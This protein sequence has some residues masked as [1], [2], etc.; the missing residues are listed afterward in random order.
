MIT[1]NNNDLV[2]MNSNGKLIE[3]GGTLEIRK[4]YIPAD[5]FEPENKVSKRPV[6]NPQAPLI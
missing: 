5:L 4:P 6:S 2:M 3:Y 1:V